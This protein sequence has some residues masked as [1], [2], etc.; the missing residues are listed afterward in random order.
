MNPAL[1]PNKRII[2]SHKVQTKVKFTPPFAFQA[3]T[4]Y[5]L[6]TPLTLAFENLQT[7][8]CPRCVQVMTGSAYFDFGPCRKAQTIRPRRDRVEKS[9]TEISAAC[10]FDM[11]R[12]QPL[13]LVRSGNLVNH[14]QTSGI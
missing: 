13:G 12:I 14:A 4:L 11:L 8:R 1:N 2:A 6:C 7:R 5:L 3:F 10:S 9:G